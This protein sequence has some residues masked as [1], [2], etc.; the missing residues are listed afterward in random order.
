MTSPTARPANPHRA[1]EVPSLLGVPPRADLRRQVWRR[2]TIDGNY[3]ALSARLAAA[4]VKTSGLPVAPIRFPIDVR[5]FHPEIRSTGNLSLSMALDVRADESWDEVHQRLLAT[6]AECDGQFFGP[7]PDILKAPL[8]VLRH[9][10]RRADRTA[11][12]DD[13]FAAVATVSNLGR[14][15]STWFRTETFEP[16][17]A[18]LMCPME[19]ASPLAVLTTES[20]G[21]TDITVAWWD[22]PGMSERVDSLL[23][24]LV[25][26]LS[27][28]ADRE[29]GR[30]THP[31]PPRTTPT[32]VEQFLDHVR[33]RPDAIAV[34]GPDGE[35]TYADLDRRARAVASALRDLG[36]GRDTMVGLLSGNTLEAVIGAWGVSWPAAPSCRWTGS[37]RTPASA[38]CWR[39]PTRWC[40]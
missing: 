16:T 3:S 20:D 1:P 15:P 10:V 28:A 5:P 25:E 35:C 24:Q 34:S 4:I 37:T 40:A 7:G 31:P 39:T 23:D 27:P 13:R 9:F 33:R 6:L 32:V 2:R 21:R 14:M 36:V 22:G 17:S 29:H 12:R 11:R 38:S 30:L 26:E 19:P 18:Y 8:P